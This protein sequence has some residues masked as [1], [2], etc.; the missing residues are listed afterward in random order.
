MNLDIAD[1]YVNALREANKTLQ[2]TDDLAL[3]SIMRFSD[4]F[5][6]QKVQDDEEVIWNA[7]KQICIGALDKFIDMRK[8]EG[9][10]M[11]DDILSRLDFIEEKSCENE[12]LSPQITENYSY[13]LYA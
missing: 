12:K 7:V 1:G 3:S 8:V 2:L 4:V 5:K 10:K 6:I 13:R 11:F 9:E